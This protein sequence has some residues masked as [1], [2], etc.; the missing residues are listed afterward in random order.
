MAATSHP[1]AAA[2][3]LPTQGR[4]FSTPLPD[5][6]DDGLRGLDLADPDGRPGPAWAVLTFGSSGAGGKA[7]GA[8][9]GERT[10]LVVVA[11]VAGDADRSDHL[12]VRAEDQDAA[13]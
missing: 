13:G 11:D 1:V 12:R 6:D 10:D 2:G 4:R 5:T 7:N 3:P 9:P 8:D